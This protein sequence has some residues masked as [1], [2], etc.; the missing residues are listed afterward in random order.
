MAQPTY[1]LHAYNVHRAEQIKK[2]V[3][4]PVTCVGSIIDLA[5]ADQIIAD[6]KADM[7]AM[8]RPHVADPDIVNK[9]FRGEAADVRPCLRCNVCGERPKDFFPVRCAVNPV[10]GRELEYRYI[11][12]AN[13]KKNIIIVGGGPAGM[14]AAMIASSRGHEV[15]LYEKQN[16]LGGA[17]RMASALPFKTD[18]KRFLEWMIR[19][20]H[21][22]SADVKLG[23][24]AIVTSI[25]DEKP[26]VLIIA[27][28]A[29][30]HIPNIPGIHESHVIWAGDVYMGKVPTGKTV[31]VAGAGLTG[32]ETALYLAQ[33]GK[34]IMIIDLIN[35][36]DIAK[37]TTLVSKMTLLEMLQEHGVVF[38][39]E[40]NLAEITDK[41]V[42]VEVGDGDRMD[43][44]ADNVI[45]SLGVRPRLEAVQ[46]FQ[47]LA[48]E[49]YVVGDC[50]RPC[51]LMS[52]IHDA[53]TVAVEI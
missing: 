39:T 16:E 20:T 21:Q 37:D 12:L 28:G 5:M 4:V 53:F 27:I 31:I 2:N 42:I 29:E 35:E 11:P 33:L 6:G 52:A 30:P 25:Q 19:Q 43:I 45:L 46:A 9:T 7:V 17:L 47:G 23:T 3:G 40:V 32:C 38:R 48:R 26:D 24:E 50:S 13:R 10:I 34:D 49:V 36:S 8:G 1:F 44:P 22:S 41:G 18:M 15:T 51:N 14:E